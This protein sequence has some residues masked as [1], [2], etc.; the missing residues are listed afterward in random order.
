MEKVLAVLVLVLFTVSVSFAVETQKEDWWTKLKGKIN[1]LTPTKEA[2][3]TTAVGGV[4]GAKDEGGEAL[5]WKGKETVS[6]EELERFS[7]AVDYATK[8][9]KQ[10]AIK[11]F[12]DFL[13][14]YPKSALVDDVK[15]SLKILKSE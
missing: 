9:E 13:K 8:G 4:R 6:K 12:E 10:E 15:K 14:K 1:K 2:T 3:S 11:R 7:T 5:Y